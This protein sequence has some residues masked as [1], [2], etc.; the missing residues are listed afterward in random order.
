MCVPR[1]FKEELLL[2]KEEHLLLRFGGCE[3]SILSGKSVK[4]QL[5]LFVSR[6]SDVHWRATKEQ[7]PSPMS[8]ENSL[9]WKLWAWRRQPQNAKFGVYT[10]S[11]H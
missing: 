11:Y 3:R 7:R 5:L 1:L 10:R 9:T 8:G 4:E 6:V 2:Y